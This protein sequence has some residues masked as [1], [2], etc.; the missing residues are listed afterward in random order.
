[1]ELRNCVLV[2]GMRSGFARGG[3]GKLEA[4]R[5][6][7]A[8]ATVI[9]ELFKRNPK[10]KPSM[11]QDFGIGHGFHQSEVATLGW[12]AR[13]AGL[14]AETTSFLSNR[15]CGSSMETAHRIAMA[16]MLG[17]YDCGLS[18]GVERM[19]RQLIPG[20]GV[21]APPTRVNAFNPRLL[22][23]TPLQRNLAEDHFDYFSV[24]IP[25][26]ILDVAM[27]QSMVQ[28]AQNVAEMYNISRE[29]L[30]T[31]SMRS[32]QKLGAAYAKG[33][34]KDEIV[35]LEVEDPVFDENGLWLENEKGPL[36]V[37]DRDES[38]RPGTTMADLAKLKPVKG[39]VSHGGQELRITAGNSCPT[40][41]GI[42]TV[43]LMS[44]PMALKLGLSP[45]ARII[46]WGVGGVKQQIMGMGPVPATKK[47][48]KHAGI[49]VDQ[50]DRVEFNEA[51]AVQVIPSIKELGIP[52]EKVN[53]NGGSIGI[54]HPIG[55]TG[56]RLL[57]TVAK[58]LRRSGKKYGLAT[59]CIGAGQG[60]ATILEALD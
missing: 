21:G 47:A 12:V 29:E 40:N 30:D 45:L 43:L 60:I 26:Y 46:G 28:T 59:Q 18:F 48:L 11:I 10:V 4:T 8:G 7:D 49:T 54:G 20:G 35:P 16:I 1:M 2:D 13:L 41:S 50:I 34:Y 5:M 42:S 51:F 17:Q 27:P 23:L 24:P 56:A 32:Q 19:G 55:A 36:I 15:Q 37:F 44:E 31:F 9:R 6:D 33:T 39:V 58:E 57:L 3:K 22:E 25:E 53:V 14:P 38:V 52:E